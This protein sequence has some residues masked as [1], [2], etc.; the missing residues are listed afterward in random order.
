LEREKAGL[1]RCRLISILLFL[2][3][4]ACQRQADSSAQLPL[5]EFTEND[6]HVSILLE[7]SKEGSVLAA[8]FTPTEAELHLYSKD[9]PAEGVDGAGRPTRLELVDGGSVHSRG[10]L[11]ESVTA[12][13]KPASD[14]LP[15]LPVYPAGPVTLR[16]PVD[17]PASSGEALHL[18]LRI[19]YM[20]CS[21]TGCRK[22]VEGKIV[23][24]EIR[25]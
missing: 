8:M 6:V 18:Q 3:L 17:L 25:R 22:P 16:L 14:L 12:Q 10:E 15:A 13:S 5:V 23:E 20:A 21:V 1:L 24:V 4:A 7:Q 19:S 11:Q 9:L 2:L